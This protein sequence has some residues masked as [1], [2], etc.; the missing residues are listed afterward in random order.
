MV[1]KSVL[2]NIIVKALSRTTVEINFT[3]QKQLISIRT[4][5]FYYVTKFFRSESDFI[6][7]T[8]YKLEITNH[9]FVTS[10]TILAHF[11]QLVANQSL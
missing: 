7:I 8:G 4:K 5:G 1:F 11:L 2:C 9:D 3:D 6:S 10:R